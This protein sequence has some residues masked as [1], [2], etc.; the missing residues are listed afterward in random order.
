MFV[1]FI[2]SGKLTKIMEDNY[3]SDTVLQLKESINFRCGFPLDKIILYYRGIKLHD[4]RRIGDYFIQSGDKLDLDLELFEI[5]IMKIGTHQ[6]K[7]YVEKDTTSYEMQKRINR[8]GTAYGI[9]M[10]RDQNYIL[11]DGDFVIMA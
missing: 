8:S 11:K 10:D 4:K 9:I 2:Q 6:L 7:W 1:V 3:Q 5:N